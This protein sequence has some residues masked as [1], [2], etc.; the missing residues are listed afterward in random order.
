M[1]RKIV[2]LERT[3]NTSM[4]GFRY[5]MWAD[6]P[7]TRQ[8]FYANAEATSEVVNATQAELTQIQQGKITERTSETQFAL[9]TPLATIQAA[10]IVDFNAFQAEINAKNP[11]THYGTNYDGS[12][13]T[14]VQTA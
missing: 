9:G 8:S 13:W 10:L 1:A 2:I 14:L 7:T 12:T 6:V 5:A 11:W 4:I 3:P